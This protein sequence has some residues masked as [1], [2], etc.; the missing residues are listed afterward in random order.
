MVVAMACLKRA[1]HRATT[2]ETGRGKD[3]MSTWRD[4]LAER[5]LLL[6]A[7]RRL[8]EVTHGTGPVADAG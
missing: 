7:F 1:G 8:D 3:T 5:V 2:A 6:K 4:T